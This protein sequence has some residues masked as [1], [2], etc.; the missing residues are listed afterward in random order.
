MRKIWFAIGTAAAM[1]WG[2]AA[3]AGLYSDDLA[4][5]LIAK[6]SDA[7]RITLMQWMFSALTAHPAVRS[8]SNITGA[9]RDGF[10]RK[11]GEL[12]QRLMFV[13]CHTETVAALKY[14]G[15]GALESGF[16]VLGQAAAPGINGGSSR[17]W[18]DG[19]DRE[20][21]GPI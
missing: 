19:S 18:A 12:F 1:T 15:N 9:Q 3:S 20:S 4:R 6:S 16:Q 11:A 5:C 21:H 17:R 13:D 14:E 2:T 7:D 8:M 10:T